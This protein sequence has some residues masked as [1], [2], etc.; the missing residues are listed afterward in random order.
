LPSS[1]QGGDTVAY[2]EVVAMTINTFISDEFFAQDAK[3]MIADPN[4][5]LFG[6]DTQPAE[7]IPFMFVVRE[8]LPPYV[9]FRMKPYLDTMLDQMGIDED[10]DQ[11]TERYIT[12]LDYYDDVGVLIIQNLVPIDETAS[13]YVKLSIH[14]IKVGDE[15]WAIMFRTSGEE[16][17]MYFPT[18][19]N[20]VRSFF[21]EPTSN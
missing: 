12:S 16:F 18:I 9:E 19:E 20:S 13:M 2:P 8:T 6:F 4:I 1:Y 10:G 3:N 5:A 17:D 7:V 11:V 15:V 14:T 21:V